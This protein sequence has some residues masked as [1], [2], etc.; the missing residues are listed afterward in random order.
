MRPT[1][2]SQT[3]RSAPTGRRRPI[4]LIRAAERA[5][6]D[7]LA[8]VKVAAHDFRGRAVRDTEPHG[9]RLG[10]A[11]GAND[12]HATGCCATATFAAGDFVVLRLLLRRENLTDARA[13]RL[14]HALRLGLALLLG[15]AGA[16]QR[17]HLLT[18]VIEDRIDLR[19][20]LRGEIE[21]LH[22]SLAHLLAAART[23]GLTIGAALRAGATT[24][25]RHVGA[26]ARRTKPQ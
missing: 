25:G 26:F 19:L 10:L 17:D 2:E 8:F 16:S 11:I 4:G 9:Y 22:E 24:R 21:R 13:H 18:H 14:A 15:K 6:D 1:S 5:G 23:A 20:L 12:P 7:L 3:R